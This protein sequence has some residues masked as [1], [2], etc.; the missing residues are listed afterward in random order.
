MYQ[1]S[2]NSDVHSPMH[3]PSS[4]LRLMNSYC[5]PSAVERT[6]ETDSPNHAI[7]AE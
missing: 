7:L 1:S 2:W 4:A 5:G 6:G 3:D